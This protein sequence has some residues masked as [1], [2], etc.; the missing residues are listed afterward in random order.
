MQAAPKEINGKC[1]FPIILNVPRSNLMSW[2]HAIVTFPQRQIQRA[3][4]ENNSHCKTHHF[5]SSSLCPS[6][7]AGWKHRHYRVLCQLKKQMGKG[8]GFRATRH[9]SSGSSF[10]L[11]S[12]WASILNTFINLDFTYG[13]MSAEKVSANTRKQHLRPEVHRM[14]ES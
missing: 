3:T 2:T 7:P 13:N 4:R 8:E 10:S 6:Q 11:Y 14:I 1:I 9:R 12:L 5:S